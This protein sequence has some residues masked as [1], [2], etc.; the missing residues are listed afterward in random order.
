VPVDPKKYH[1][2]TKVR[3]IFWFIFLLIT[4]GL[5]MIWLIYGK[6]AA[7]MGFLCLIGMAVPVGLVALVMLG[8]DKIV[9]K[10]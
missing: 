9:K 2:Q 1:T 7:F 8:L 6:N 3:L 10:E 4:V 5:G